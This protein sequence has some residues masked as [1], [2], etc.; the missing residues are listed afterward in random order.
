MQIGTEGKRAM[1]DYSYWTILLDLFGKYWNMTCQES[2]EGEGTAREGI[3]NEN[4]R[5][6]NKHQQKAFLRQAGKV[7]EDD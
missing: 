1:L 2:Y 3:N 5:A 4:G 6:E 7:I